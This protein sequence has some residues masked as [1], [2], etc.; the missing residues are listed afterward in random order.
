MVFNKDGS[1]EILFLEQLDKAVKV[2]ADNLV[3]FVD[4]D[5][6]KRL[7]AIYMD[8][9]YFERSEPVT[10]QLGLKEILYDLVRL[11]EC[12][13]VVLE[14]ESKHYKSSKSLNE[15]LL[16]KKASK[17]F[18]NYEKDIQ[19][20]TTKKLNIYEGFQEKIA[21]QTIINQLVKMCFKTVTEIIKMKEYGV[22]GFQQVQIDLNYM[23]YFCR[24]NLASQD[25]GY[26]DGFF[27]DA[28]RKLAGNTTDAKKFDDAVVL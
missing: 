23:K 21:P 24:E 6:E 18:N 3:K 19:L 28:Y 14:E 15:N 5:M 2:A 26:I 27:M 8:E 10:Y 12:L 22:F 25:F 1:F 7:M 20:L 17:K 16:A 13:E 9:D 11:K 4:N